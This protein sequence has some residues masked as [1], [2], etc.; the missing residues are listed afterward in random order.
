MS[1]KQIM[2]DTPLT[3][4]AESLM[5]LPLVEPGVFPVVSA[6][7][8]KGLERRIHELEAQLAAPNYDYE[9]AIAYARKMGL[10]IHF[11]L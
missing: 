9:K 1:G 4:E 11:P 5:V 10:P 2:S 7:F 3:D 8:A 6:R